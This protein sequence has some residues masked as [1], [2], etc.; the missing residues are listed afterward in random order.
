MFW[1]PKD[2]NYTDIK[3]SGEKILEISDG[4]YIDKVLCPDRK[5]GN[6]MNSLIIEIRRGK[7]GCEGCI[8]KSTWPTYY[9]DE[10]SRN[11]EDNYKK[12]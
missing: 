9:C 7:P 1:E 5:T 4:W 10:C 11:W 8:Y 12:S 2:N 3:I 6:E